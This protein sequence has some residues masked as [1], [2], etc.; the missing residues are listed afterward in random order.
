M[1]TLNEDEGAEIRA[2]Y[3]V[4]MHL[5]ARKKTGQIGWFILGLSL[6]IAGL[7]SSY[8]SIAIAVPLCVAVYFYLFKSCA[9][10][11]ERKTGLPENSQILFLQ[12]YKIDSQFATK[13]NHFR[14]QSTDKS[15]SPHQGG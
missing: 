11:V 7:S 14:D 4:L 8:W 13:V 5:E 6:V 1:D 3:A 10:Y 12:Q 2:S 9:R 15:P